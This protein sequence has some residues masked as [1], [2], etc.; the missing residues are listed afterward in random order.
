M[1]LRRG[2]DKTWR[3][4]YCGGMPAKNS[5]KQYIENGY[6]HIYNRGVE[7]REIF[8]DQQDQSVFLRYLQEYLLPKNEKDLLE[9]LSSPT[10]TSKE[11]SKLL[12]L[13]AL[14]NFN[15][16]IR[17]LAYCL[18]PNHFHFFVKQ[19]KANSI[20]R[21]M[22]SLGTRYTMYFNK[23]YDRVGPL[24]QGEYKAV[25]IQS[26]PQFIHLSRYIHQQAIPHHPSS[27]PV[28]LGKERS[29]WV[30]P[31]EVLSYF[32]ANNPGLSYEAFMKETN[33]FLIEDVMLES[34]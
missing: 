12:K 27:Y 5:R 23:K 21:F 16:E 25:R 26:E 8:M 17:F 11:K 1:P 13:L 24:Y 15:E 33:N 20:D 10:I 4:W 7:K 30:D 9:Q 19:N 31:S 28:Y 3:W 32:S 18:M 2:L 34:E 29:D 22:N 14:N 6:Y